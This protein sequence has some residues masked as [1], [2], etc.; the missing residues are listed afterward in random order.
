MIKNYDA[1]EIEKEILLFWGK[2]KV[3]SKV[4]AQGKGKKSYYFLDGPPYTSGKIHLGIAWNKALKDC[5]LRYKRMNGLDVWDR[6]GYDMHGLPT[7]HKV[8]EKRGMKN[9]DDIP[10]LG[11]GKFI[12]EC[13]KLSIGNMNLMTKDFTRIGVWMDFENAYQSIKN[14]FI[15]G[16][17]WLVKKAYENKRLYEGEKVMHWCP[18]CA[19]ALAKHELEYKN[20][21]DDSIFLKFKTK[22]NEYLILWT[23]TPWTIAYN[24]GIMVNPEE[25]Y[26]KAKVD[27]EVWVVA[28]KLANVFISSLDKKFEIIKEFKGSKL[29]GVAYE[30]PFKDEIDYGKLK[31]K[32]PNVH[33][34]LLST[35][36]VDTGS[37]SGLVHCAPGC[38]PEDYEVGHKYGIKPFNTLDENG[39]YDSSMGKF[40]GWDAKDD[41]KRLVDELDKKGALLAIRPV[42][43]E[44]AHCWRCKNPVIFRTTKQWFFKVEDLKNKMRELNKKVF[45]IPDWAGNKWFDSWLDNLRDNG[46]T[47]QRYWGTPLPIWR[48][49]KCKEYVVVGSIS[50]LKKLA[51]DVPK[52]LHRPYIDKV[53]IKC[54]CGNVMRRIPDILDVWIDAGTTSWTCLDY[55][56]KKGLFKKLWPPNFILEGKDQIRG[57]FNLLLV[58]SMV[59]MDKHSYKACY[60]HGFVQDAEG[61]KMSKSLGN[62]ISPYEVIDK[63]GADTLR[64]Y[65]IGGANPGLDLNYNMEDTKIKHKNLIVLWNLHK[66]LIDLVRNSKVDVKKL[67]IDKK[68]FSLEEKYIISKLN[69]TI[70]KVNSLF[71]KYKLDEVPWLIE[72][73]YL[74]LSRTYIQLTREKSSLGSK[75]EKELVIAVIYYVLFEVLKLSA[76]IMPFITEKIYLNLKDVFGLKGDSIHMHQW[77]DYIDTDIDNALEKN[78]SVVQNVVQS[79]LAGREKIGRGVRWPLKEV[80]IVSKDGKVVEAVE[81]LEDMVKIQTN[82]KEIKIQE[83]MPGVKVN[84]KAD[85]GK[86]GPDFGKLAPKVVVKVSMESP[87]SILGHIEKEGKFVVDIDGK[88]V[89]V[90]KEHLIVQRD[91]PSP[92][93]EAEFRGGILYL[94]KELSAELEAEGFAREV[95][96]RVQSLRKKAGLEKKDRIELFIK[97]SIDLKNFEGTIIEKVGAKTLTIAE[98]APKVRFDFNSKEKVKGKGFEIWLSK[99]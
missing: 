72:G 45:W 34:I 4:K 94:N 73:L 5:V 99:V 69:S 51:K 84:V 48:C 87:E 50:E 31:E 6:A 52:D 70:K 96:R 57:W 66:Y 10:K 55:P 65:I 2:N 19:T 43:H 89:N 14:E 35:E 61:R 53:E 78:I 22:E 71:E 75:E 15:G 68:K 95:M 60:M 18:K 36:Y 42:E 13:K 59:S 63:F 17:W 38:G 3:Y 29:E 25:G 9:K 97:S 88:K 58:A 12:E 74:E 20:V 44:Y 16:E 80:I 11:V 90:V 21:K 62:I 30:H 7:A 37:G 54:K 79:V 28:K 26:V 41:N 24:L 82:V 85:F 77:P 83:T 49:G 93:Q 33:T 92:Y 86:I 91:V 32:N 64:Y 39:K 98:S 40:S 67:K 8:M 46:I 1:L 47:R 27:K 81:K 56:Q 23:T 76:P